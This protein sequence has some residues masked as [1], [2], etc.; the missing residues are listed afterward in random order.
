MKIYAIAFLLSLSVSDAA[1]AELETAGPVNVLDF[2]GVEL[3]QTHPFA[4]VRAHVEGMNVAGRTLDIER[5][6]SSQPG[7]AEVDFEPVVVK[8]GETFAL[9]LT[10]NLGA[11]VGRV[12]HHFDVYAKGQAEPVDGF[13]VHGFADWLISPE[14][15]VEFGTF[16]VTKPVRRVVPIEIQP[17][18]SVKL[19]RIEKSSAYFDAKVIDDGKALELRSKADAPWS[20]FDEL[21]FVTTSSELQPKVAFRLR[22][23]ARGTVV[24]SAD[25]L[26][27]GLLREGQGA[28]LTLVLND[29]SGKPLKIGKVVPDSRAKVETRLAECIPAAP[30]CR[31]LKVTYP[32][33]ELRGVTGGMLE[34][35]LPLYQRNLFVRFGAIG[36]GKDTKIMDLAE[37]LKK[38]SKAEPSVSSALQQSMKQTVSPIEMPRPNGDGP[39]LTWKAAHEDGVYGYEV[40]RADAQDGPFKRVSSGIIPRLDQ[41]G[42]QGSVY[43]WRDADFVSGKAYWYYVNV[44]MENGSK[45]SFT[46]A[47][48]VLAK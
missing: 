43:R 3:G 16:E 7:R 30:S 24:S 42:K 28:E 41:S 48:R 14:G 27:F 9:D 2:T 23:Q 15:T 4:K 40:Y 26:D 45:R 18:T 6:Q 21:L 11:D 29:T 44:V 8:A 47:Q 1:A 5:V 22:G 34:I 46:G 38:A 31:N 20:S 36:I 32:P 37:E 10:V 13:S 35:E 39:L 12:S 17:G 19:V 25:P 33:M